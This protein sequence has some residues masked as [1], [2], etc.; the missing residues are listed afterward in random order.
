MSE[1]L[2]AATL[3]VSAAGVLALLAAPVVGLG[4]AL[5][6]ALEFWMAAALLGLSGSPSWTALAVAAVLVGIRSLL[7]VANP[8]ANAAPTG[9]PGPPG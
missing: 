6:L 2:R 9:P 4:E 3:A 7:Q 1:V 8:F 5:R